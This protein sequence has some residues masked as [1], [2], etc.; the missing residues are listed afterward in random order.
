M[1]GHKDQDGFSGAE[2]RVGRDIRV[3]SAAQ[4]ISGMG[5]GYGMA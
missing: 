3:K 2:E 4:T 1:E 5:V